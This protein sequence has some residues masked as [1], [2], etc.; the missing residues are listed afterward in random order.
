MNKSKNIA[1]ISMAGKGVRT[2]YSIPKQYIEINGKPIF[3]YT[4]QQIIQADI[5]EIYLMIQPN[6]RELVDSYLTNFFPNNNFIILE[7]GETAEET[8]YKALCHGFQ[9]N[10]IIIFHD[11]VRPLVPV[12]MINDCIKYT[13]IYSNAI[14][15]ILCKDCMI[16]DDYNKINHTNIKRLQV[17]QGFIYSKILDCY[18]KTKWEGTP[19]QTY[20][21]L[22]NDLYIF[23]GDEIN[24]KVTTND[25][26]ELLK[27]I[28]K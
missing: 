11:A 16:D 27:K 9:P 23:D 19:A 4:L 18:Q 28:L 2:N 3:I 13:K 24:F 21:N 15:T 26:I 5:D 7:G 6:Y 20:K 8:R 12:Q 14:P 17:P 25:D 10:D 1:I 22:Y